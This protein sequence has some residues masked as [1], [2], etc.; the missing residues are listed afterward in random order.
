MTLGKLDTAVHAVMNDMLTP[1]QAA[2]A[3]HVPQRAL[4]EALRRSQEKQQTRWQ[5]LMHEKARLEQSLARINK[6]LH[7]QFV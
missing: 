5:K 2:K 7:E 3:Y 6:E 4:Y 1:S